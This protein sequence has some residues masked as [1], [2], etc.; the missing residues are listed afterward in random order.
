MLLA[1]AARSSRNASI[2]RSAPN[3]ALPD[4]K[5]SAPVRAACAARDA[6]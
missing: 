5:T 4:T 2:G 3:T 1:I 6:Q